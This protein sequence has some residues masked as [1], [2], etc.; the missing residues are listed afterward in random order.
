MALTEGVVGLLLSKPVLLGLAA[1]ALL[2]LV[3]RALEPGVDGLEPPM[4]RHSIP[5]FGHFYSILK[6]QEAFFKCLE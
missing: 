2:Y 3:C 6:D 4:L 1:C 5:L